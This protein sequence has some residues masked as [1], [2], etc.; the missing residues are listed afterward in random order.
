MK[1][2]MKFLFMA[3][4]FY[5]SSAFAQ[6][7]IIDNDCNPEP[8]AAI[9]NR[10]DINYF[11]NEIIAIPKDENA[12]NTALDDESMSSEYKESDCF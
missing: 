7:K 5:I 10:I 4:F 8:K 3:T 12:D 1:I 11:P 6:D 2:T 9:E